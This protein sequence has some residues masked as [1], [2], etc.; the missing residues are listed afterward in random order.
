MAARDVVELRCSF[1]PR[2]FFIAGGLKVYESLTP[3]QRL[4][5][6]TVCGQAIDEWERTG[7]PFDVVGLVRILNI[8]AARAAKIVRDKNLPKGAA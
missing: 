2:A 6:N 4:A 5:V 1:I 3:D 8:A 7:R